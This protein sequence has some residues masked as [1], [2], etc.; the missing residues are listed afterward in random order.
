MRRR[1]WDRAVEWLC[2]FAIL[3]AAILLISELAP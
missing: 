1:R 2:A 3:A